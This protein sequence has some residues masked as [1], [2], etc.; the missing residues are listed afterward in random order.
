MLISWLSHKQTFARTSAQN[1]INLLSG[2]SK[3]T[4]IYNTINA[5]SLNKNVQ[6]PNSLH[7][8]QITI[9][10]FGCGSGSSAGDVVQ[11]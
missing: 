4:H 11:S 8:K 3:T 2:L 9:D 6:V 10:L 5:V 1:N 7:I